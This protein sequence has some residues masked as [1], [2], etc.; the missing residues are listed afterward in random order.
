MFIFDRKKKKV[1]ILT[2]QASY[3]PVQYICDGPVAPTNFHDVF[4]VWCSVARLYYYFYYY[5]FPLMF[6]LWTVAGTFTSL[7][8]SRELS[9]K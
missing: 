7:K 4:F 3:K 2:H 5:Y 9:Q 8:C 6:P 1:S